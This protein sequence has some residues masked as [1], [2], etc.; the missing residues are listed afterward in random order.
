MTII[1]TGL[2]TDGS[3]DRALIPLITL[4]LKEH[5]Q[6]PYDSIEHI[7]CD[8][9]VLSEKVSEVADTYSLDILFIHRDAENTE[10]TNRIS[11]ITNATPSNLMGKVIAVIPVKMTESWLLTDA[12]VI[13]NAVGNPTS[14]TNLEIPVA[15]KLETCAAKTVL[16]NALTAASDL[17]TQ[18]RRKFKPEK[19]RHRVAELTTD[20]GLLRN[21]PSFK[22]LEDDLKPLLLQ[23]NLNRIVASC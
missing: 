7:T 22:R 23:L 16:L 21:I 15:S 9:N 10:W 3:S 4:L 20:L 6:L 11:E 1:R 13:R 19:F 8:T 17:G 18:R 14:T 5:L 12:K 2:I